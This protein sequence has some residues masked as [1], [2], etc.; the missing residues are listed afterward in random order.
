MK[1]T[2]RTHKTL[3]RMRNI[4]T[5]IIIMQHLNKKSKLISNFIVK[6]LKYKKQLRTIFH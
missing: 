2:M 4:L 5:H 6:G 3:K 1:N